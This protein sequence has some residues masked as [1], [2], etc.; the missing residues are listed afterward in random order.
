MPILGDEASVARGTT[1]TKLDYKGKDFVVLEDFVG[2]GDKAS[3]MLIAIMEECEANRL[4]F[5]PL[6]ALESGFSRLCDELPDPRITISPVYII[7]DAECLSPSP[8]PRET[9]FE[10]MIR[11]VIKETWPSLKQSSEH[12]ARAYGVAGSG[13]F[14]VTANNSPDNTLPLIHRR[15]ATWNPLFR[16]HEP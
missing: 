12:D 3:P 14:V 8:K 5:V 7:P 10:K 1:L 15:T 2:N 4:L 13:S 11:H 16:R 6:L 9:R